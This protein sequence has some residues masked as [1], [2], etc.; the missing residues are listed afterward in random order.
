MH[1]LVAFRWVFVSFADSG[2]DESKCQFYDIYVS[3]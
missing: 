2:V 1:F 3:H